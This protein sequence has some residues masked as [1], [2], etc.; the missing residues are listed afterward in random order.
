VG[1]TVAAE[2]TVVEAQ[3]LHAHGA[4]GGEAGGVGAVGQD[5]GDVQRRRGG[6]EQ[7]LHVGAAAADE[8][9]D[10]GGRRKARAPPHCL[11]AETRQ[12]EPPWTGIH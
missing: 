1:G 9:G 5:E 11:K 6:A 10:A 7:G 8:D 3:R 4:G 12:G 2:R